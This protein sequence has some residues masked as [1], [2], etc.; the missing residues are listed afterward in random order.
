MELCRITKDQA[1][2]LLARMKKNGLIIPKGM[3]KGAIYKR[4]R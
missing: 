3:R 1:Y 4:A 2:K